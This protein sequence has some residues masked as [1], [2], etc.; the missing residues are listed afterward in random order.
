EHSPRVDMPVEIVT[1]A[2]PHRTPGELEQKGIHALLAECP[3][4]V[5]AGLAAEARIDDER[6]R[7]GGPRDEVECLEQG[8]RVAEQRWALRGGGGEMYED[9][10]R[11]GR[12]ADGPAAPTVPGGDA[13]R[14]GAVAAGPCI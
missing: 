1:R 8:H 4:V 9:G 14:V 6:T 10:I 7:P 13:E 12:Q 11:L 3:T 2:Q 5:L